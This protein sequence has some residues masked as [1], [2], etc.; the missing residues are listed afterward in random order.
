MQALAQNINNIQIPELLQKL[1]GETIITLQ[2]IASNE[3]IVNIS[4]TKG[5][6]NLTVSTNLRK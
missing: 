2:K 5:T 6:E 3:L 1:Q 4:D